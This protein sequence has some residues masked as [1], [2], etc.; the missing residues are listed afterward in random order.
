M[1]RRWLKQ[2][3][4][5]A[6]FN[7]NQAIKLRALDSELAN[8]RTENLELREQ[9]ILLENQQA[10]DRRRFS[11]EP[12]DR[13]KKQLD[14]KVSELQELLSGL[15][16]VR[17]A[18]AKS[19]PRDRRRSTNSPP[20]NSGQRRWKNSL[21]LSDIAN[22]LEG[23]LDPILEDA[24]SEAQ[25]DKRRSLSER[26]K[27]RGPLSPSLLPRPNSPSAIPSPSPPPPRNWLTHGFGTLEETPV[28]P[29][30][31]E[32]RRRRKD[33]VKQFPSESEQELGLAPA[34]EIVNMPI[35]EKPKGMTK[36]YHPAEP[37]STSPAH[38]PPS[39]RIAT[40]IPTRPANKRNPAPQS[41]SKKET[42][43]TSSPA[44]RRRKLPGRNAALLKG[45]ESDENVAPLE[46]HVINNEQAAEGKGKTVL[47]LRKAAHGRKPLAPKSANQDLNSPLKQATKRLDA[48][49]E[50]SPVL[51]AADR[52][53]ARAEEVTT[54]VESTAQVSHDER[55]HAPPNSAA[56]PPLPTEPETPAPEEETLPSPTST[57]FSASIYARAP[58]DTP[59]P[60]ELNPL[61]STADSLTSGRPSRRSRTAVSYAQPN[62]RDKMRRP[63]EGFV[64][65]VGEAKTLKPLDVTVTAQQQQQHKRSSS[66][67]SSALLLKKREDEQADGAEIRP[68]PLDRL[69]ASLKAREL[70]DGSPV[71][72]RNADA[73]SVP[74]AQLLRPRS[75]TPN[76]LRVGAGRPP[77]QLLGVKR[78]VRTGET[79]IGAPAGDLGVFEF[80]GSES[81]SP[82]GGGDDGG[83]GTAAE[84]P[85]ALPSVSSGVVKE[86][87]LEMRREGS[88]RRRV[89]VGAALGTGA[90]TI[91][92][93]VRDGVREGAKKGGRVCGMLAASASAPSPGPAAGPEGEA[94]AAHA[95]EDEQRAAE[96]QQKEEG[97][98]RLGSRVG[99]TTRRRSMMV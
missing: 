46:E 16:S 55:P 92:G 11:V 78:A 8:L 61:I 17:D 62:L 83:G 53:A 60:T 25:L 66:L 40:D 3:R 30:N 75:T 7:Q 41:E 63:T 31:F 28:P 48:A 12:I 89:T 47:P 67:E 80:P 2:N 85:V 6:K 82:G 37:T 35:V 99:A 71:R 56:R 81:G 79:R 96:E 26:L 15:G 93:G 52:D 72:V 13:L 32:M 51:P 14:S 22:G 43:T 68:K 23:H 5:L 64:D 65:A 97:G 50:N 9:K 33:V 77:K 42:I 95:D 84:A 49:P 18:F 34:A 10:R 87:G 70:E 45:K 19:P 86:G 1:K 74:A 54:P 58:L 24:P 44:D 94:D 76:M 69:Y 98:G 57:A 4:E 21:S 27:Q 38:S 91:V 59:P 20:L 36:V 29:I 88:R 73:P 39:K 90:A